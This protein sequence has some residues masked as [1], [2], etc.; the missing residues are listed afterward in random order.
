[1]GIDVTPEQVLTSSEATALLLQQRLAPGARVLAIGEEGLV[2]ALLAQGFRLVDRDP[3]VVVCGLDRRLTYE[4]LDAGLLA[5]AGRPADRHQPDLSL[6]TEEGCSPATGPPWP[7]SSGHRGRAG[8]DRQ[9][10]GDHAARG[11]GAPAAARRDG[12]HGRRAADGHPAG[13]PAG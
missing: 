12:D 6:P 1:M 13:Q 2:R 10:G 8:G 4:R 3:E 11:D 9:A 7:T 5:L